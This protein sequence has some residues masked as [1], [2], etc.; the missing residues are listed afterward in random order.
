MHEIVDAIAGVHDD[1]TALAVLHREQL[2]DT[3]SSAY[4]A[5][6][7]FAKGYAQIAGAMGRADPSTIPTMRAAAIASAVA[8]LPTDKTT[9]S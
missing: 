5:L 3:E 8:H 2:D 4:D 1:A 9:L 6:L 7:A